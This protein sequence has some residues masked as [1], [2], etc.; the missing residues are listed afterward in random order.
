MNQGEPTS[1][2]VRTKERSILHLLELIKNV[3]PFETLALV[4]TNAPGAAEQLWEKVKTIFPDLPEPLSVNVTPVL[5]AH[6]GPN[7][8]GFALVQRN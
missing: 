8:V 4:H 2:Q 5:G 1:D 3:Q 7:A 6:L